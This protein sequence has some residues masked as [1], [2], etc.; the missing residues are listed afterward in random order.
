VCAGEF[1]LPWCLRL[2]GG[3]GGGDGLLFLVR[4]FLLYA[5]CVVRGA[6]CF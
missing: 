1:F 5:S 4:C 2:G 3:G 6:L